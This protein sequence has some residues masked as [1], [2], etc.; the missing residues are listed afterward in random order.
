MPRLIPGGFAL[1]QQ[2]Q[3]SCGIRGE[4]ERVPH[5]VVDRPRRFGACNEFVEYQ[6]VWD[7]SPDA[8]AVKVGGARDECGEIA[9]LHFI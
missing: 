3:T 5:R 7:G 4:G 9:R 1:R 2:N 6:N 8:G